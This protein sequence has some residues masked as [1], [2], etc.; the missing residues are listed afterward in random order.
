MGGGGVNPILAIPGFWDH[1]V[2]NPL[3]KGLKYIETFKQVSIFA[4]R[5]IYDY[6]FINPR[7]CEVPGKN[8]L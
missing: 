7:V 2:P 3:P 8:T 4:M 6:D 1:L 5:M